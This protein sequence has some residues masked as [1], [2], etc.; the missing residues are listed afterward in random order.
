MIGILEWWNFGIV[1]DY[2]K[3][4]LFDHHSTIPA[5]QLI[6]SLSPLETRLR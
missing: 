4:N 2:E 5:F 3:L 1:G 6:P